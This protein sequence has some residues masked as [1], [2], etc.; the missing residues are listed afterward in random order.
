MSDLTNKSGASLLTVYGP[1]PETMAY[2]REKAQAPV[3]ALQEE[4]RVL[5]TA[6]HGANVSYSRKVFI[7]LTQLCRNV[8]HYCTFAKAPSSQRR[9]YLS[10]AQVLEIATQ[11]QRA[12]CK[13]ALFT[14]GDKPERRYHVAQESLAAQGYSST[15]AYLQEMARTVLEETGLIPHINAG[16]LTFEDYQALRPVAASMGMMLEST[17]LRLMEKGMAHH[18]SPDKHPEVRLA[19]LVAAGKA[20]VPMTSGLLIGIGETREERL[21]TL[22]ILK[23]IHAAYGHIQEIIIQN[24]APKPDTKMAA[25]PEVDVQELVWTL[26]IARLIFGPQMNIQAPPNLNEERISHLLASGI[27]DWGGISPVTIDHVN[28]EKM[29]PQISELARK[30]RAEG[31]ELVERLC[32][33]PSYVHNSAAWLDK[34]LRPAVIRLADTHGLAHDGR[35]FAGDDR[36]PP[37]D[38]P[39]GRERAGV[40]SPALHLSGLAVQA[41]Q[42]LSAAQVMDLFGAYGRN[43]DYVCAAAD[44]RRKAQ[45]GDKVSYVVNRNINYTN[46]C[47]YRCHFCAFAKG[48]THAHLRGKAYLLDYEEIARRTKEAAAA[49]ATEVCLQGGIHPQ[50]TGQTYLD[51]LKTV[52]QAE[53]E[54]HIH[55]FSPLE[56][57]HG[58]ETLGL[59]LEDFLK[60]LKL[61]GLGTMPGTAAEILDDTVRAELCPDKLSTAQWREVVSTAHKVG[62]KTTATIMFGH[63]ERAES[64]VQ[65]LQILRAIQEET[66]GL[67]E[68]VPLPF[69]H[70]ESPIY[71]AGKARKGPTWREAV[72][73]HAVARLYFGDILPNIQTSWV[74][75][76]MRGAQ[77]CLSAG[78]ND[79]GGI[80]MD[81]TISRSAGAKNGGAVSVECLKG[82]CEG[83]GR[84]IYQRTTLYAPVGEESLTYRDVV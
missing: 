83:A 54:M 2:W 40:Q 28:P 48:K 38:F 31:M 3:A 56:V 77:F 32:L 84:V 41:R 23:S 42:P 16:V 66:G 46:I 6:G 18:G 82:L 15:L 52:K 21:H 34:A 79:L 72:L 43:F 65:H 74:K 71:L 49:G 17:S 80:L 19:S 35:W 9:P 7:P 27:N 47:Q 29:W 62:L 5:K 8:C 10:R 51:I 37:V 58:A 39:N 22:L 33:Y 64:W 53:P 68:F 20:R 4:A 70:M 81:E 57:F 50:F 69:V 26:A 30:T 78:A 24:F 55:A 14:L 25:W 76:G 45:V 13:E 60:E 63:M 44:E 59:S 12:G 75:M 11:G 67:T 61:A 73:M 1:S 36:L